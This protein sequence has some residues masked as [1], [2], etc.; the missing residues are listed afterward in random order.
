MNA[1]KAKLKPIKLDGVEFIRRFCLHILPKRFVKIRRFGIY[2]SCYQARLRKQNS[3]ITDPKIVME[4][5]AQRLLRITRFDSH[6]CPL[7]KKG[8][9]ISISEL[10]PIRAPTSYYSILNNTIQ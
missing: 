4:T 8:V 9:M 3:K 5:T 10:P 2:S 7:C 1:K 6:A